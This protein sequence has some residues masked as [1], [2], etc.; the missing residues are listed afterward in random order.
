M[1]EQKRRDKGEKEVRGRKMEAKKG[2]RES[3][4]W[5]WREMERRDSRKKKRRKKKKGRERDA[6]GEL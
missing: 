2:R 1:S 5:R 3:D 4:T 6:K